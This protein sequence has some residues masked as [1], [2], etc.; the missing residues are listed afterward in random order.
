M[1]LLDDIISGRVETTGVSRQI[2]QEVIELNRKKADGEQEMKLRQ[3]MGEEVGDLWVSESRRLGLPYDCFAEW[4]VEMVQKAVSA[5]DDLKGTLRLLTC[6]QDY[7]MRNQ[8]YD[9]DNPVHSFNKQ[10]CHYWVDILCQ[11]AKEGS[12]Y[13]RAAVISQ[14]SLIAINPTISERI[15]ELT[16]E[17]Q[18][19]YRRDVV[20]QANRRN[21]QAIVAFTFFNVIGGDDM[22][23]KRREMFRLAGELGSSEGYD[24]L[25]EMTESRW[26][27]EEGFMIARAAAECDDGEIAYEYM[28]RLGDAYWYADD[29]IKEQDKQTALYWYQRAARGGYT[30]SIRTL[31]ML[32]S[33][34]EI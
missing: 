22:Q 24:Q 5:K 15:K 25:F 29:W 30:S 27:S 6:A 28:D 8:K 32:K 13:A 16:G 3:Q 17:E 34:G 2:E 33:N 26:S 9:K 1:G 19:E 7:E 20:N 31:E 11:R 14:Y 21:P 4:E 10:H 23:E 18:A 12:I